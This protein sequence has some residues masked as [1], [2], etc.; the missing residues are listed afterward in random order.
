[1]E[2][3]DQL[4]ATISTS[5]GEIAYVDAGEGPPAVFV[6][7]VFT[8]SYLWRHVITELADERRC[9]AL[10]LPCHG[11]TRIK[12]DHSLALPDQ[13]EVLTLFC[14]SLDLDAIDLVANDTGGAIAQVF[15]V[16]HPDRLRTLV[17]TNCD[18]H[19]EL[20]PKAFMPTVEAA[21][22]GQLAPTIMRMAKDP[23]AIRSALGRCYEHAELL[24]DEVVLEYFA[25]FST[26]EGARELER[27]MTSLKAA[28]LVAIEP[29]LARLNVPTLIVWGTADIFFDVSLAHR[30]KDEI[31][32][33]D[34]VIEIPGAKLFFPDERGAEL[35]RCLREHW[36]THI[37]RRDDE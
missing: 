6:H 26:P 21:S 36:T 10:D 31:Q 32:G 34:R 11:R 16:D 13:A 24:P 22:K 12:P 4:R 15:A 23:G 18:V 19:D 28:D 37:P 2:R 8:S 20:P 14:D 9:I 3:F 35:A 17:L 33:A 30:L 5:A 1:L 27:A 25:P 29:Q 7:G